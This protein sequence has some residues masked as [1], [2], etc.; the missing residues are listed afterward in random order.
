M[1]FNDLASIRVHTATYPLFNENAWGFVSLTGLSTW[2]QL[3]ADEWCDL[4]LPTYMSGLVETCEVRNV[5]CVDELPGTGLAVAGD[6]GGIVTGSIVDDPVPPQVSALL[7]WQTDSSGRSARGR[8]YIP[9]LP[10]GALRPSGYLWEAPA[11]AYLDDVLDAML[12]L[13]GPDGSSGLARLVVIS[14]QQDG[15]IND[16]L[17][18]RAVVSGEYSSVIATQRRRLLR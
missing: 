6:T 7:S 10:R 3:L 13:Y 16:P 15:V 8:T 18:Y 17:V 1:A 4:V 5:L 2:R 9:A 12:D 11:E 14:R